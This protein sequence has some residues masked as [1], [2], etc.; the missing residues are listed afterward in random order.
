MNFKKYAKEHFPSTA[1]SGGSD[2]HASIARFF[3]VPIDF[4]N[5]RFLLKCIYE[6]GFI[7]HIAQAVNQAAPGMEWL[8][9]EADFRSLVFLDFSRSLK[10]LPTSETKNLL[11]NP[12]TGSRFHRITINEA[13]NMVG[14]IR[15]WAEG[16]S[17][18]NE[19]G[20]MLHATQLNFRYRLEPIVFGDT[21]MEE[22]AQRIR[23]VSQQQIIEESEEAGDLLEFYKSDT[24]A[25]LQLENFWEV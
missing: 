12:D 18:E 4:S 2:Y 9:N 10:K 19:L 22:Q 5:Q 23:L 3:R 15:V 14:G 1:W 25:V 17:I 6:S 21:D 7:D 11:V 24:T 20:S 8:M 13:T 16:S